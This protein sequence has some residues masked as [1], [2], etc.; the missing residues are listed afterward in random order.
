MYQLAKTGITKEEK[1]LILS[2]LDE[3]TAMLEEWKANNPE[4]LSRKKAS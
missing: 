3:M 1:N 2:E 4:D